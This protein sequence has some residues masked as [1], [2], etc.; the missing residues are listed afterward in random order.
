MKTI[1]R[2]QAVEKI[3]ATNGQFF[4][5]HF[6]KRGGGRRTMNARLGVKKHLKGGEL[7]FNPAEKNLITV[8]DAQ[9]KGYRSISIEGL[10]A[11]TINNENFLIA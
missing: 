9:K 7:K 4:T 6:F 2:Q 10:I 1:T 3:F 5:V 8:F 11:V